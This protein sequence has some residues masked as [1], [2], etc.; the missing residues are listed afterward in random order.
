M[1]IIT[2]KMVNAKPKSNK[3]KAEQAFLVYSSLQTEL[4]KT[5]INHIHIGELLF[6]MRK[7]N[8]YKEILGDRR[9][10]W[11]DFLGMPE[12]GQKYHTAYMYIALYETFKVKFPTDDKRLA[13]IKEFKLKMIYPFVNAGNKEGLLSAA[14][15]LSATDLCKTLQELKT[16]ENLYDC[17]HAE[18]EEK[19]V[20]I[21][22]KC[23][24]KIY[25]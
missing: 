6:A 11:Q 7:N 16:G 9:G 2:G 21:C 17:P 14:E 10:K 13:A 1:N 8:L 3:E 24:E 20:R 18:I 5:V 19:T 23:K 15:A 12:I 22:K 4:K 25:T